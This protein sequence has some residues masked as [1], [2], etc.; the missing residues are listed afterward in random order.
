MSI[1]MSTIAVN[2]ILCKLDMKQKFSDN[3]AADVNVVIYMNGVEYHYYNIFIHTFY[4]TIK[5]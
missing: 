4:F 5:W 3:P 2:R 1:P